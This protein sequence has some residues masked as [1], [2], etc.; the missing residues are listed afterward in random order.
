MRFTECRT[1]CLGS[2]I[3]YR[4]DV[5]W[6]NFVGGVEMEVFERLGLGLRRCRFVWKS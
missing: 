6:C 3:Q 1:P 5:D 2:D 4:S